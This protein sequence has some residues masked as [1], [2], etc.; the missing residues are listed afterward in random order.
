MNFLTKTLSFFTCLLFYISFCCFIS[1]LNAQQNP[2]VDQFIGVNWQISSSPDGIECAGFVREFSRWVDT[3]SEGNDPNVDPSFLYP[4][5][6]LD[7]NPAASGNPAYINFN[8]ERFQEMG[9]SLTAEMT[10][11]FTCLFW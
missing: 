5:E 3:Q 9:L 8:Y 11:Y 1:P 7:L 4:D 2:T 6:C 10:R